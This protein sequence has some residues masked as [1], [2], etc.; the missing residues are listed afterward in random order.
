MRRQFAS[1]GRTGIG[2][3]QADQPSVGQN[4]LMAQADRVQA[5]LRIGGQDAGGNVVRIQ[6]RGRIHPIQ[7]QGTALQDGQIGVVR[8]VESPTTAEQRVVQRM[9]GEHGAAQSRAV[10][11]GGQAAIRMVAVPLQPNPLR[12]LPP[13]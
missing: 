7:H 1:Y 13:P 6:K 9:A 4:R 3:H 11:S 12:G 10:Q 5:A 2:G 8:Q